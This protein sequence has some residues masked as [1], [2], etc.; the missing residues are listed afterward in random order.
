MQMLELSVSQRKLIISDVCFNIES[1]RV[2]IPKNRNRMP[3]MDVIPNHYSMLIRVIE[4]GSV[5]LHQV[6][7]MAKT[8]FVVQK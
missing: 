3:I 1:R 7:R 6:G 8:G 2:V 4:N 5:F